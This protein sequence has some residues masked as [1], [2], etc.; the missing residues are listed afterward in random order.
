[1]ARVFIKI[2]DCARMAFSFVRNRRSARTASRPRNS[3]L[4]EQ[5]VPLLSHQWLKFDRHGVHGYSLLALATSASSGKHF[6]LSIS[7]RPFPGIGTRIRQ[8][9]L[10]QDCILCQSAC[11]DRLLCEACERELPASASACPRC[12][13]DGTGNVECGACLADPPHYDASCAAFTYAFPV[14]VLVQA[15]KYRGQ[16]ALAG[17]FAHKLRQRIDLAAGV[18]LIVPLPLHPARLAERGFNQAAEIAKALSRVSG[19]RMDARVA[20][21]VRNTAPQAD[22]PWRERAAN[23][24]QAFSCEHDLAGLNVAVVDD[25]MT[26]GATLNEFARTLKQSGAARVQNWVVARTPPG[27]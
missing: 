18:D 15:L 14:D 26:T 3:A 2:V 5:R 16:L 10:A 27:V 20:R 24:R 17:F 6:H 11:G 25:V 21:R 13:L 19:I 1:M 23:M 7:S 4:P 12:A 9:L 22:L 8:G